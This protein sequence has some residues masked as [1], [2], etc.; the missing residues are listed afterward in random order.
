MHTT[1]NL[2]LKQ[3]ERHDSDAARF[4]RL[5]A[6][7]DNQDI[8]DDLLMAGAEAGVQ[9]YSEIVS[10]KTRL[11]KVMRVLCDHSLVERR[12]DLQGYSIHSCVHAWL[13]TCPQ[14]AEHLENSRIAVT[15][16]GL[17]V[18]NVSSSR[19]WEKDLRLMPHADN[20]SA[21]WG[22]ELG[23]DDKGPR[24]LAAFL[25]LGRLYFRHDRLTTAGQLFESVYRAYKQAQGDLN[26][27]TLY[28]LQV[29][30]GIYARQHRLGKAEATFKEVLEEY[31]KTKT[32][33]SEDMFILGVLNGLGYVYQQRRSY[34]L[35]E[36]S[37]KRVLS[38]CGK[39][40][41]RDSLLLNATEARLGGLYHEQG[42]L[43]EAGAMY[44]R[45]LVGYER[46]TLSNMHPW[47]LSIA[48]DFAN[49]LFGQDKFD[50]AEREYKRA[51][52]GLE[53]T[54]GATH[55]ST[56]K[57][58]RS[59]RNLYRKQ[60]RTPEADAM[61]ERLRAAMYKNDIVQEK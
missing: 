44:R 45:A 5:L 31:K 18:P 11:D 9:W 7:L 38:G 60:G 6:C 21:L 34:T 61:D 27:D 46:K 10:S 50:D 35:A 39:L 36:E 19:F 25:E 48:N 22:S 42:R 40:N 28:A 33:G 13:K 12:A 49:V 4:L 3:L 2:S 37:F 58:V 52:A 57:V 54:L 47:T 23:K 56:L 1:W 51:L 41:R 15:C 59:L 17:S 53:L 30:G 29:L 20:L 26:M 8:W 43:E 24:F 14:T 32:H 16:V 55:Q